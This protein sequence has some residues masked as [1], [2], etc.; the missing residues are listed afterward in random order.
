MPESQTSEAPLVLLVEDSPSL[1]RLYQGYLAKAGIDVRWVETG[2]AAL[3]V[4]DH[5]PPP[6]V[7]LDLQLPDMDGMGILDRLRS[8]K[9]PCLTIVI[10]A[11]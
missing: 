6:V 7:L 11:H 1:A 10:T 4:L 8:L 5:A 9:S 2:A 3:A